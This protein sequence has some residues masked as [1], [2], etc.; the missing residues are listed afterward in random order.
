MYFWKSLCI[1]KLCTQII[2]LLIFSL[3]AFLLETCLRNIAI[4]RLLLCLALLEFWC[5]EDNLYRCREL[6]GGKQH[7]NDFSG[8]LICP[9]CELCEIRNMTTLSR[10]WADTTWARGEPYPPHFGGWRSPDSEV[11]ET[12]VFTIIIFIF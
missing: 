1:A 3:S 4:T 2:M 12:G 9:H 7:N 6:S 8:C 10:C 11:F 5:P